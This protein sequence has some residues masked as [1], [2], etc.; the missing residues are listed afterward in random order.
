MAFSLP[1][2][3]EMLRSGNAESLAGTGFECEVAGGKTSSGVVVPLSTRGRA[4]GAGLVPPIDLLSPLFGVSGLSAG[5]GMIACSSADEVVGLLPPVVFFKPFEGTS[6]VDAGSER[7]DIFDAWAGGC[8]RP[9]MVFFSP[10]ACDGTGVGDIG[11]TCYMS[12][13]DKVKITKLEVVPGW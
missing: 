4:L 11:E 1:G 7:S 5:S 10:F 8:F 3:D 12:D 13:I 9:P 6:A 2:L